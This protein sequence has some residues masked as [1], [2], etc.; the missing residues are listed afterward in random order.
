MMLVHALQLL[1]VS[2]NLNAAR[3]GSIEMQTTYTAN[4]SKCY[5]SVYQDMRCQ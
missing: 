1:L 4:L 5:G 2:V 3:V